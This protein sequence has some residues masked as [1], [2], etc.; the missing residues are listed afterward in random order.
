MHVNSS[1]GNTLLH[2]TELPVFKDFYA[3]K[4][5]IS[6]SVQDSQYHG[7]TASTEHHRQITNDKVPRTHGKSALARPRKKKNK[8]ARGDS[9]SESSGHSPTG[10]VPISFSPQL[11]VGTRRQIPQGSREDL[12][13]DLRPRDTLACSPRGSDGHRPRGHSLPPLPSARHTVPRKGPSGLARREARGPGGRS[14][15]DSAAS[16]RQQAARGSPPPSPGPA[17]H[18]SPRFK[19]PGRGNAPTP[20][21]SPARGSPRGHRQ[22]PPAREAA[23]RP[24]AARGLRGCGGRPAGWKLASPPGGGSLGAGAALLRVHCVRSTFSSPRGAGPGRASGAW[25]EPRTGGSSGGRGT[26]AARAASPPRG[27]GSPPRPLLPSLDPSSAPL[28]ETGFS[29]F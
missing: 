15:Q 18:G 19:V 4:M 10:S 21:A 22:P 17:P 8:N 16:R 7:H 1:L 23:A 29:I 12:L 20:Q 2:G 6:G 11:C 5:A 24:T 27:R 28:R 25:A 14:S 26:C 9:A 13:R 3:F